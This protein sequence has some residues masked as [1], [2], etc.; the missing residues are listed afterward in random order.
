MN[1]GDY[2]KHIRAAK[3]AHIKWRSYAQALAAGLPVED[4]NVPI[5][6]TDCAFGQWYYGDGQAL[7]PLAAF[8]A[9]EHPHEMMHRTYM[10]LFKLLMG[11]D[12]GEKA[13]FFSRLVGRSKKKD[14]DI[15]KVEKLLTSIVGLSKTLLETIDL[16]E[17]ELARMSDT[18]VEALV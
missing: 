13:G 10:E 7:S 6:H 16:L 14:V 12:E 5:M 11:A 4:G 3:S 17:S 8:Q 2:L 1:K 18:E 15:V 9:I